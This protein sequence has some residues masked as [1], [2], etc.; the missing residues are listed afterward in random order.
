MRYCINCV[1]PDTRPRVK[2]NGVGVCYACVNADAKQYIDWEKRKLRLGSICN[3]IRNKKGWNCLIPVSGGKNSHYQVWYMK[4]VMKMNPLLLTI[5]DP[6][7]G[8][9]AGKHNFGNMSMAF[10]VDQMTFNYSSDLFKRTARIGFE[11]E[12]DAFKFL[13]DSIAIIPIKLAIKLGIPLIVDG[14]DGPFE[15]GEKLA[16]DESSLEQSLKNKTFD[17]DYWLTRGVLERELASVFPLSQSEL[18]EAE[19]IGLQSIYLSHYDE[20][21]EVKHHEVAMRH[22]FRDLRHE[23]DR[24][25][26]ID[27]FEQIDSLSYMAYHWCKY[28]KFGYQR[29]TNIA[30]RRIRQGL[31]TRNDAIYLVQQH[32]HKLDRLAL[33]DFCSFLG[34][35]HPEFWDVV[36]GFW[37]MEIFEED[38][39]GRHVLKDPIYKFL[40]RRE[41][42][43]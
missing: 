21:S 33:D 25:G 42:V 39:F 41:F 27:D 18:D 22:G 40:P 32:D 10:N 43:K 17:V 30:S 24:E 19:R 3:K 34:Y 6:F 4:E 1:E 16:M 26:C 8:T 31:I 38:R 28:P 35:S 9:E 20:W 5:T 2:F 11:K 12:L 29:T 14:E 13:E 36:D 15:F 37:N 7:V 23:W